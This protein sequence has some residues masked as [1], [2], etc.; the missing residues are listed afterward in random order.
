MRERGQ[1]LLSEVSSNSLEEITN[2]G[3]KPYR[4]LKR[5]QFGAEDHVWNSFVSETF[6]LTDWP[7]GEVIRVVL[8]DEWRA[9][10]DVW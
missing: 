3:A 6:L 2:R 8:S 1:L 4:R 10:E 5:Q 7:R 9:W